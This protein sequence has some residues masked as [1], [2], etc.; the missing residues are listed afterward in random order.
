MSQAYD[1]GPRALRVFNDLRGR[2][3]SGE[4]EV[5]SQLPAHTQLATQ[6]GV[7]PMTVRQ[8]LARLE[9]EGLVAREQGRGTF[10]RRPQLPAVLI[11]EDDPD[12]GQ[13]IAEILVSAG[14]EPLLEATPAAA[15][16]RLE[17]SSSIVLVLSDVRVPDKEAGSAFISAVRR[18]WPMLP[19]AAVTA[20]P[21]DLDHLRGTPDC[22]VLIIPKP[23]RAA[24]VREALRL[25]V[26]VSGPS[27][28]GPH[29]LS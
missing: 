13:L 20:Y 6:F 9:Q 14:V 24:Q 21:N 3:L 16:Q 28:T 2:I 10:V 29:Q 5:G 25:A 23:F 26:G 15:L 1:L 18:R 7:A 8:V 19:V 22:P 4:L 11:L 12:V 17:T 27:I